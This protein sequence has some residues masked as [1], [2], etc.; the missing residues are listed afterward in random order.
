MASMMRSSQF[1]AVAEDYLKTVSGYSKTAKRVTDKL[2]TNYYFVGFIHTLFPKA[3]IIHTMRNPGDACWS[4]YTKLFKDDMPHSYDLRELG[5]YYIKYDEIMAH[6]RK[7]LPPGVMLEV[8]YEDVVNDPETK[9]REMIAF[10]GLE[11]DPQCLKFHE[12]DR[13]VKTASV[14][15]IRKPIYKSSVARWPRYGDRMNPLIDT[16]REGGINVD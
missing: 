5:R 8:K 12:S 15:Q 1:A 2:L 16:L 6:W 9:A 3:K 4:C 13:P 7:I 14:S 11:W 10:C